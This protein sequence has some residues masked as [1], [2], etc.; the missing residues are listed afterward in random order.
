MASLSY[1]KNQY[2]ERPR[3]HHGTA[4]KGKNT[5]PRVPCQSAERLDN[6]PEKDEDNIEKADKVLIQKR[7]RKLSNRRVS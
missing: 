3:A 2:H 5:G 4:K 6:G 1:S 7:Y